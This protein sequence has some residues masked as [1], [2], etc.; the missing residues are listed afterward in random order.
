MSF[1][2]NVFINCPFDDDY[3]PLLRALLFT[4]IYLGF[5]PRIALESLDS[6]T[7]R[8]QKI[9]TLIGDSR[10]AIHDLSRLRAGVAGE[11]YRLNMPFELGLDVGCRLFG[12]G[13]G[14]TKR[15]LILETERYRYQAALSDLSNSDIAVH[16]DEP[17][18]IVSEVRNWLSNQSGLE[19][20]GPSRIWGAFLEF[21]SDN[22]SMLKDRGFSDEDIRKLPISELMN[23]TAGWV[24]RHPFVKR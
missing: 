18:R 17:I 22:F 4:V 6:G 5:K 21:T 11:F 2:R 23:S 15:C 1:E 16:G 8:I 13:R 24:S 19:A 10:Y 7:P 3:V 12:A 14:R 9:V 20:P